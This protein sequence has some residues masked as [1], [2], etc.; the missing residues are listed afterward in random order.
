LLLGHGSSLNTAPVEFGR[1][2]GL[3]IATFF[4][5]WQTITFLV[6][7]TVPGLPVWVGGAFVVVGGLAIT[8]WRTA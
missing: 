1:I 2:A 5:V 7:R 4:V 3:Y 8:Y 6:F